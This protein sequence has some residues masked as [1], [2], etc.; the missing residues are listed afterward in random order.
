MYSQGYLGGLSDYRTS[1]LWL[2]YV[3]LW[4]SVVRERETESGGVGEGQLASQTAS[5][6][7]L[8]SDYI[9]FPQAPENT[10]LTLSVSS[11]T[12]AT[13][14][15]ITLD[16]TRHYQK[17]NTSNIKVI[18]RNCVTMVYH[19]CLVYLLHVV[20]FKMLTERFWKIMNIGKSRLQPR[21]RN[22]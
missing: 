8:V 11:C 13:E 9:L 4:C 7:I 17:M 3:V 18:K 10:P 12:S 1:A 21:L 6:F 22:I 16:G 14:C 19:H 15:H 2:P 5:Q 20:G